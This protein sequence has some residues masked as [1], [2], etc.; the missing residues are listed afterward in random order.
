MCSI[1]ENASNDFNRTCSSI[2]SLFMIVLFIQADNQKVVADSY[3]CSVYINMVLDNGVN[4]NY[5]HDEKIDL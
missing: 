4:N 2:I 1:N 3:I 5:K